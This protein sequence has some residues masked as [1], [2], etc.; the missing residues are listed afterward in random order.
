MPD[1][2][3]TV[4]G[5]VDL[6][7][8]GVPVLPVEVDVGRAVFSGRFVGEMGLEVSRA[9]VEVHGLKGA[10]GEGQVRSGEGLDLVVLHSV[11]IVV[12]A[13]AA[14]ACRGGQI[15]VVLELPVSP[16][17]EVLI[18]SVSYL[19]DLLLARTVSQAGTELRDNERDAQA[20]SV[21]GPHADPVFMPLFALLGMGELRLTVRALVRVARA[22]VSMVIQ[23]VHTRAKIGTWR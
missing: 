5:D 13:F 4:D 10:L 18:S 15:L 16:T 9:S 11:V 22:A 17:D 8:I 12:E 6:I 7:A 14:C 2:S 21:F 20:L 3:A 19:G 23:D 1:G